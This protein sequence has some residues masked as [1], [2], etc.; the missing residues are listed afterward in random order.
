MND[1][2]SPF[3]FQIFLAGIYCL[4]NELSA[5]INAIRL[6]QCNKSALLMGKIH[7]VF[8]LAFLETTNEHFK[9]NCQSQKKQ[10]EG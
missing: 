9:Y 8:D 7:Y 5:K 4:N 3:K 6:K 2:C 10:P 1:T